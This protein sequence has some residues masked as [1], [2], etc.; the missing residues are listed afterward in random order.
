MKTGEMVILEKIKELRHLLVLHCEKTHCPDMA[1]V[2][3]AM[4]QAERLVAIVV[5]DKLGG[6]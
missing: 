3:N 2:C 6:G 5:D 1:A 4:V